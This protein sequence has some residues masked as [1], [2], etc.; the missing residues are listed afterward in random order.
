MQAW[1]E[2]TKIAP[3]ESVCIFEKQTRPQKAQC[4]QPALT[5]FLFPSGDRFGRVNLCCRA[6]VINVMRKRRERESGSRQGSQG[7]SEISVLSMH[8]SPFEL[9]GEAGC[10]DE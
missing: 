2:T 10:P 3:T 6:Q 9:L 8:R 5:V 1:L 7:E 4:S